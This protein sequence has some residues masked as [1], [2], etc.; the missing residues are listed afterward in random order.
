M[1]LA[2][3]DESGFV[4]ARPDPNQPIQ[5]L[6]ALLVNTRRMH[7]TSAE[8]REILTILREHDI[9]LEELKAEEIY[10]GRGPW[11][12]VDGEPRHRIFDIYL[13]WVESRGH[14]IVI[15]LV[16]N[17]RFFDLKEEG[18]QIAAWLEVPYVAG[19]LHVAL[20][21]QR[22]QQTWKENK[23]KTV[24]IYD[25][26]LQYQNKVMEIVA[27]PS[28]KTDP[29]YKYGGKKERL[30]QIIDTAYYACSHFS[31]LVQVADTIAFIARR[32]AELCSYGFD[33]RF[34]GECTRIEN[35]IER[36]QRHLIERRHVYPPGQVPI[37]SFYKTIAPQPMPLYG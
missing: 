6:A 33:E 20:A 7:K 9:P 1:F 35:W 17:Q 3:A 37:I 34:D 4:G 18:S 8:F 5:A 21:I 12:H 10:G 31:I 16:D 24:L 22:K 11:E 2:Y 32:H 26:Q 13:R 36:I 28:E 23:G 30:D 19:A 29:Y 15:S 27:Q 14:K 25:E